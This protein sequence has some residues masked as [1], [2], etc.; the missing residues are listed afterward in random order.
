[1]FR[2]LKNSR[3][4][5]YYSSVKSK[6][7][8]LLPFLTAMCLFALIHL[9]NVSGLMDKMGGAGSAAGIITIVVLCLC[10]VIMLYYILS[11]LPRKDVN[12]LDF[13]TLMANILAVMLLIEVLFVGGSTASTVL[14]VVGILLIA[15]I[16]LFRMSMVDTAIASVK[17]NLVPNSTLASY[18]GAFLR[19]Y[20]LSL[21]I[22]VGLIV[23]GAIYL[24]A[25]SG[26]LGMMTIVIALL[27]LA[28]FI[29]SIPRRI[30]SAR[31][32]QCDFFMGALDIGVLFLIIPIA[33]DYTLI[34]LIAWLVAVAVC[35]FFTVLIMKNTCVIESEV[36]RVPAGGKRGFVPYF[37]S[38]AKKYNILLAIVIGIVSFVVLYSVFSVDLFG[39]VS[40]KAASIFYVIACIAVT[41]GVLGVLIASRRRSL[42]VNDFVGFVL[43]VM[44]VLALIPAIQYFSVLKFMCW[45]ILMFVLISTMTI[46]MLKVREVRSDYGDVYAP[47]G[48]R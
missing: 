21:V 39:G 34:K 8:I 6:Y 5:K 32:G 14:M 29:L 40:E 7:G 36:Q 44:A 10:F 31:M 4:G 13:I 25:I 30:A 46:R 15:V 28:S 42:G 11:K 22:L 20:S 24:V 43:T 47:G 18:I 9:A 1:M 3:L 37:R 45:L 38:F 27:L 16:T 48:R 2:S 35:A 41:S 19:R 23:L 26:D 33:F 17:E 12:D